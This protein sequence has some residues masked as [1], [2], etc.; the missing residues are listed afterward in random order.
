V[1]RFA[2]ILF[3]VSVLFGCAVAPVQE[4]SDARQTIEAARDA[5][6]AELAGESLNAAENELS[7]A[8]QHLERGDYD[9]ARASARRARE[10]A[11]E[12]RRRALENSK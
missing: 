7:R 6:A 12:A 11:M 10:L 1:K 8:K 9:Q 5:G 3:L 4:M 2:Y